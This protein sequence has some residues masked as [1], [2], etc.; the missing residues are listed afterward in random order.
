MSIDLFR[1]VYAT[2]SRYLLFLLDDLRELSVEDLVARLLAQL[3]FDL[4]TVL[5]C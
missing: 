5:H 2:S 3:G 4:G 1:V